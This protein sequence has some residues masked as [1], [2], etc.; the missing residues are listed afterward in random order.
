MWLAVVPHLFTPTIFLDLM[1]ILDLIFKTK[2]DNARQTRP[3]NVPC[4]L[5]RRECQKIIV[6][7]LYTRLG[8]V[9]APSLCYPFHSPTAAAHY[10][11]D[12]SLV[13]Q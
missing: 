12:I 7:A 5:I 6:K 3:I 4:P 10:K 8:A 11:D 13:D 2:L 9:V 1:V